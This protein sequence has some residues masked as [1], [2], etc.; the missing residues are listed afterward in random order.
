MLDVKFTGFAALASPA[1]R[2]IH[3]RC[4]A[5]GVVAAELDPLRQRQLAR[6]IDRVGLPAHV[7]EAY[8]NGDVAT[9][10]S[11]YADTV[12]YMGHRRTSNADVQRQLSQYF[13][14]WPVRQW[15]LVGTVSVR[16]VGPSAQRVAFS[17]QYDLSNPNTNSHAAGIANETLILRDDGTG[18]MKITSHHE[19]ISGSSSSDNASDNKRHRSERQRVYDGR[20]VIPLPPNIPWPPGI[21]H[22]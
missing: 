13:A 21:P 7:V 8:S 22:P 4:S 3:L 5:A 20:P 18:V 12:D 1:E 19:K 16:P 9:F 15:Q 10:A 6:K 17:A 2:P 14:K 11:L